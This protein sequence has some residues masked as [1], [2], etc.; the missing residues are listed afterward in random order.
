LLWLTDI[1]EN[2]IHEAK[3]NLIT[4]VLNGNPIHGI[5]TAL[6][7]V[8][9]DVDFCVL[10]F[11]PKFGVTISNLIG[12]IL[13]LFDLILKYLENLRY[14]DGNFIDDDNDDVNEDGENDAIED[15]M[16]TDGKSI[17][18]NTC[19]R[20]LQIGGYDDFD[21]PFS[22]FFCFYF[23][24]IFFIFFFIISIF[25]IYLFFDGSKYLNLLTL[26]FLNRL[27]LVKIFQGILKCPNM[28]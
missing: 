17:A 15:E 12:S 19:W 22:L 20:S 4:A 28:V 13:R 11:E 10:S 27:L 9:S 5:T 6:Y 16:D 23:L 18:F 1:L 24:K 2:Q 14:F 21:Y 8:L 26:R 3:K 7:G 25:A